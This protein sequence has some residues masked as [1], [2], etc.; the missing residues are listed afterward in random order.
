MAAKQPVLVPDQSHHD[1]VKDR[2][3]D[4]AGAVRVG[5]AIELVDDE[6]AKDD[7]RRRRRDAATAIAGGEP[8]EG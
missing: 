7:I 1:N 2:Q 6:Q 3:H 5:E 8:Q 4:Q